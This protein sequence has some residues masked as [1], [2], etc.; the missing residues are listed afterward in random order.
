MHIV[1]IEF[2]ISKS[3][4]YKKA[5]N[6]AKQLPNYTYKDGIMVINTISELVKEYRPRLFFNFCSL[7]FLVI[8]IILGLPVFIQY[9]DT[10]L[11]PRFPSLIV[12]MISL[13]LS[14]L[15]FITGIIL[16]VLS[17]KYNQLYELYLNIVRRDN[18]E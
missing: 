9:F 7:V 3:A 1:Y 6:L 4:Q 12:S 15:L 17:K 5:C 8:A 16:E 13:V 2:G 11:V 14:L 10:G 18:N